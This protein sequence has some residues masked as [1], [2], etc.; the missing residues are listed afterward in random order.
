MKSAVYK[1]ISIMLLLFLTVAQHES[2]T[3]KIY[4]AQ[5]PNTNV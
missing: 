5:K 4:V 2:G 1:L 3:R